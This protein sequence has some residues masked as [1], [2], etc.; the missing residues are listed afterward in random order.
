M[1]QSKPLNLAFEGGGAKGF[2]YIGC[3]KALEKQPFKLNNVA[4]S[5][6]G[7]ISALLMALGVK[8][9][10]VEAFLLKPGMSPSSA[11]GNIEDIQ[12]Y[13]PRKERQKMFEKHY[14]LME[15]FICEKVNN[16]TGWLKSWIFKQ[17]LWP[18][19]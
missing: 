17:I 11:L 4:G 16:A 2:M 5:S 9:H 18:Q 3:L 14:S 19:I 6:A 13:I 8:S 15:E 10:D 1:K 7:A 12:D